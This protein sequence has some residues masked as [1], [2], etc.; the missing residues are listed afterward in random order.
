MWDIRNSIAAGAVVRVVF[1]GSNGKHSSSSSVVAAAVH[2]R[3]VVAASLQGLCSYDVHFSK[4]KFLLGKNNSIMY[5]G[6]MSYGRAH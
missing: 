6:E 4:K 3:H 2:V 5:L 1:V